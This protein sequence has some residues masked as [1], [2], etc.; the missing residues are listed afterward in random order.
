MLYFYF[1]YIFILI[2]KFVRLHVR[3]RTRL[4]VPFEILRARGYMQK[5]ASFFLLFQVGHP[6]AGFPSTSPE[7]ASSS[8]PDLPRRLPHRPPTA[9]GGRRS[10]KARHQAENRGES[11]RGS[12]AKCSSFSRTWSRDPDRASRT[13]PTPLASPTP[14][15]GAP[16]RTTAAPPRYP[17]LPSRPR[18][19]RL[20]PHRACELFDFE[21]S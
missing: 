19:D 8:S 15:P 3:A 12:R 14:P 5:S 21:L 16:G 1:I 20:D 2:N 7:A 4:L 10:G 6:R 13:S 18:P 11:R 17:R 9:S